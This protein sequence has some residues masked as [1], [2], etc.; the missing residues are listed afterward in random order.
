MD[1][2]VSLI[3]RCKNN[4]RAAFDS[5]L[6]KYEGYLYNVCYGYTFNQDE[7]LDMMQEVYIK[8]FRNIHGFDENRPFLP[9]L[10]RIAI[11]TCLNY[12]RDNKKLPQLSLDLE[13]GEDESSTLLDCIAAA[14]D[15]E[16]T[17]V[18]HET[19]EIVIKSLQEL[20]DN[21]RLPLT[22]RYLENMNYEEI[23]AALK[24]PVGTVK[25]SVFRAR[26]IMKKS[27]QAYGILEV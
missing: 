19:Q 3:K 17:A 27:L 21:Y 12:K 6:G 15:T 2:N 26:N 13:T 16:E 5:L 1:I 14:D 18:F 4:E 11:N 20:P 9:W 22:L 8:I 23:A 7:A 24:Q 25:N 10:K